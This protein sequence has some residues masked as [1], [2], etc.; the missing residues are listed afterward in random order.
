ML[1]IA[2][3]ASHLRRKCSKRQ[4]PGVYGLRFATFLGSRGLGFRVDEY[5]GSCITLVYYSTFVSKVEGTLGQGLG[6]RV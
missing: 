4:V 2:P 6:F 3:T 1:R 5:L